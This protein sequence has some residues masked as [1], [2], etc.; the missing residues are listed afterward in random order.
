M[1]LVIS[2]GWLVFSLIL[3]FS[4]RGDAMAV[5]TFHLKGKV[6]DFEGRPVQDAVI[7]VYKDTNTRRQPDFASP[8]SDK[9]GRFSIALPPGR[10]WAVA[11]V[12]KDEEMG[13]V[14]SGGKH[15]GEPTE[16][17]TAGVGD[18]EKDF[19]VADIR[20]VARMSASTRQDVV[21]IAGR[22]L[23]SDG[24]PVMMAYAIA[25]RS[26][27]ISEA[28]DY[29]SGWTDE[30]GHYELYLPRGKYYICGEVTFPPGKDNIFIKEMLIE[31]D[32]KDFD[33][34]LN[35]PLNNPQEHSSINELE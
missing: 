13:P 1:K 26:E 20:E 27:N 23:D 14:P 7:F 25:N 22:I 16:I 12:K 35:K 29:L 30:T 11:R 21:R 5:E 2:L 19:V 6:T 15:S 18:F 8:K 31:S 9:E 3:A 17:D 33:I 32:V 34:I 4:C 28:P 24:K 10:Y